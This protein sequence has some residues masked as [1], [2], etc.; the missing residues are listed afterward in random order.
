MRESKVVCFYYVEKVSLIFLH[1]ENCI[2]RH[3]LVSSV[4]SRKHWR[5][6]FSSFFSVKVISH[7]K[8]Y[9]TT[10]IH[11]SFLNSFNIISCSHSKAWDEIFNFRALNSI[12]KNVWGIFVLEERFNCV[13]YFVYCEYMKERTHHKFTN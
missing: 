12:Y 10:K 2:K 1:N 11:G 7:N 6:K 9:Q 5:T 8:K 4:V 13:K 3:L